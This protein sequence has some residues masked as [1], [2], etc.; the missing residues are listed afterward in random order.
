MQ[1]KVRKRFPGMLGESPAMRAMTMISRSASGETML[2][3]AL[4]R[5]SLGIETQDAVA[6]ATHV[7]AVG[8]GWHHS[9]YVFTTVIGTHTHP[10]N[11]GKRFTD[12]V[13]TTDDAED[14]TV[15]RPIPRKEPRRSLAD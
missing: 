15:A 4:G 2:A 6:T 10:D 11:V 8:D 5:T 1:I 3:P 7:F 14:V 12:I 13:R 9:G